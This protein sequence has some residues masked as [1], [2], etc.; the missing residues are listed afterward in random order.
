MQRKGIYPKTAEEDTAY[1]QEEDDDI[2][3][4]KDDVGKDPDKGSFWISKFIYFMNL[5]F[6]FLDL[7]P[8][9]TGVKRKYAPLHYKSKK[10]KVHETDNKSTYKKSHTNEKKKEFKTTFRGKNKLNKDKI[11]SKN[12]DQ[13][14]IGGNFANKSKS[15]KNF[16]T[17]NRR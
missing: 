14:P 1:N 3:Y 4:Y 5:I 17:K 16:K 6:L 8:S 7:F 9:K 12:R 2:Q 15:K 13:R 10:M 11:N